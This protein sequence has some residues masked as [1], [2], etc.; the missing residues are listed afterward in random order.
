MIQIAI[1]LGLVFLIAAL[2]YAC[3]LVARNNKVLEARLHRL[4][5]A[6]DAPEQIRPTETEEYLWKSSPFT[7][8]LMDNYFAD[9][10]ADRPRGFTR[11]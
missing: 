5:I 6:K 7:D 9:I 2:T 1:C 10:R 4:M 8:R 3:V 11:E